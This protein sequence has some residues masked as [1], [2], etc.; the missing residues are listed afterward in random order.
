MVI[1]DLISS[2]SPEVE[3]LYRFDQSYWNWTE[4][5]KASFEM[6]LMKSIV[7]LQLQYQNIWLR[8]VW[9]SWAEI[10]EKMPTFTI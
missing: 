7:M 2:N 3:V 8:A 5:T 10:W 1:A 9:W 4:A 6:A